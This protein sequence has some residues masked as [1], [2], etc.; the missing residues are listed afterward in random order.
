MVA[1][2]VSPFSFCCCSFE[3]AASVGLET[4]LCLLSVSLGNGANTCETFKLYKCKD[5]SISNFRCRNREKKN[6]FN[7]VLDSPVMRFSDNSSRG[8][9]ELVLT[10][11]SRVWAIMLG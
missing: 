11:S 10:L 3:A 8:M 6:V 5:S 7:N 9:V 4:T 2:E 1:A